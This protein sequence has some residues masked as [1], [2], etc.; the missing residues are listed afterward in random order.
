MK[1]TTF[2]PDGNKIFFIIHNKL[3]IYDFIN[4]ELDKVMKLDDHRY[5]I[6]GFNYDGSLFL[7]K[8]KNKFS[9]WDANSGQLFMEINEEY[10]DTLNGFHV[11]WASLSPVDNSLLLTFDNGSIRNVNLYSNFTDMTFNID[12]DEDEDKKEFTFEKCPKKIRIVKEERQFKTSK[13]GF[14]WK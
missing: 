7:T 6:I 3:Y 2:N 11:V 14:F 9:L 1:S 10:D 12:M 4:H 13:G 8:C 5:Y